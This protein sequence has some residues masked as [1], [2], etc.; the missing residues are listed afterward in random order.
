LLRRRKD[1][2]ERGGGEETNK[3]RT[4][5]ENDEATKILLQIESGLEKFCVTNTKRNYGNT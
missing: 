4:T 2:L 5:A 3:E 1:S